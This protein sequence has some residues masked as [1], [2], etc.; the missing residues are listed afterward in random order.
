M[1]RNLLEMTEV[2]E[3]SKYCYSGIEISFHLCLSCSCQE[4]TCTQN[5]LRKIPSKPRNPSTPPMLR[6]YGGKKKQKTFVS[7][8]SFPSLSGAPQKLQ[9]T[10]NSKVMF[11]MPIFILAFLL[12]LR[13]K[14]L[15]LSHPSHVQHHHLILPSA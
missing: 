12:N 2:Q 7:Y 4:A 8:C 10:M 15:W 13:F 5:L 9:I 3:Y 14:D 11:Q 6:A 1:C